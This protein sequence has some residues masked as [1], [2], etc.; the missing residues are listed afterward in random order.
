VY[1]PDRERSP[2]RAST[3][4]VRVRMEAELTAAPAEEDPER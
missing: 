1:E 2:A 3:V 4:R